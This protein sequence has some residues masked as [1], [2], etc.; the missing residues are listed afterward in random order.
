MR[1]GTSWP[2]TGVRLRLPR[3][4]LWGPRRGGLA[5]QSSTQKDDAGMRGEGGKKEGDAE[6]AGCRGD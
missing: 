6:D 4:G 1:E 2:G 5:G 3:G